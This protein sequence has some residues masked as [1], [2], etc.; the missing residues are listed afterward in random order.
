MIVNNPSHHEQWN[1]SN[2]RRK[3]T[4]NSYNNDNYCNSWKILV[5]RKVNST[6]ISILI[7]L[8]CF[9]RIQYVHP[10][11][12]WKNTI[13]QNWT[14]HFFFF[15]L[16]RDLMCI[17]FRLGTFLFLWPFFVKLGMRWRPLGHEMIPHCPWLIFNTISWRSSL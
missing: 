17:L 5:Y 10:M 4:R 9:D 16:G 14:E 2:F 11:K 15:W 1:V 13:I 7:C 12:K 6:S 3:R 8:L